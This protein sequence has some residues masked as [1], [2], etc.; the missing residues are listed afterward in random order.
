MVNPAVF[1]C[2]ALGISWSQVVSMEHYS[3]VCI[4]TTEVEGLSA[5]HQSPTSWKLF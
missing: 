2:I 4:I 1:A 3:Y 5:E